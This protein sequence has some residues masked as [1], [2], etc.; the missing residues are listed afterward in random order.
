MELIINAGIGC[1]EENVK[2]IMLERER[3]NREID[4]VYKERE[5]GSDVII[6]AVVFN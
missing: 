2:Q 6:F 1:E 4:Y 3:M 5:R